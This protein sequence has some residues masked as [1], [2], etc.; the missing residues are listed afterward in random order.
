MGRRPN[1]DLII[2][3]DPDGNE[4]GQARTPKGAI[5]KI[6]QLI[7]R[8]RKDRELEQLRMQLL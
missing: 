8:E 3:T 4:R 6:K 7:N 2:I 5:K 1:K